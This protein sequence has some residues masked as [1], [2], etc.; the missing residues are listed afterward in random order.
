MSA[1]LDEAVSQQSRPLGPVVRLAVAVAAAGLAVA[2]LLSG[3]SYPGFPI[4]TAVCGVL[5]AVTSVVLVVDSGVRARVTGLGRARAVVVLGLVTLL[6]A[7][8]VVAAQ[9]DDGSRLRNRWAASQPAFEQEVRTA[10]NPIQVES[11][12][13]SGYFAPY[14]G[15]CPGRIGEFS[16]IDCRTIDGGFLFLQTQGALTDDSG[17]VYLPAGTPSRSE[18]GSTETMTPLGGPWWSWTCYC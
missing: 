14:L 3:L 16:I 9:S 15:A 2:C 17:I 11:S 12:F 10:G 6:F 13:D 7:A 4:D 18:W 5:A 1:V 8:G